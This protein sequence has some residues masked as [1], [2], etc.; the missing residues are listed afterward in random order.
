MKMIRRNVHTP[1]PLARIAV[2][3]LSAASRL[4]P[5]KMPTNTPMGMVYVRANGAVSKKILATLGKGAL[6]RTTRSRM[7][8]RSRVNRTK[9]NT[10]VPMR[11]CETTSLRI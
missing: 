2:I 4:N 1:R 3:S 11:A 10:A 6:L 7:R 8:P 9:V 5:I